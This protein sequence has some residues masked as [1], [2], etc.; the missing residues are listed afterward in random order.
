MARFIAGGRGSKPPS[1]VYDLQPQPRG[2]SEVAWL[3][4]AVAAQARDL[5][6]PAPVNDH[7]HAR[8]A[9]PGGRPRQ[10]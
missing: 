6:L 5:G 10:C 4:G 1:L 8:A 7:L 9:G 2:R 3:N